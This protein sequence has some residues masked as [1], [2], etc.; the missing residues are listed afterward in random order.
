MAWFEGFKKVLGLGPKQR[1]VEMRKTIRVPCDLPVQLDIKGGPIRGKMLNVSTKGMRL[2][3]ETYLR[4][5]EAIEVQVHGKLR[6]KDIRLTAVVV[7]CKKRPG[8]TRIYD[9]GLHIVGH[10]KHSPGEV[11]RILAPDEAAA[12]VDNRQKRRSQRLP[13]SIPVAFKLQDGSSGAGVAKDLSRR[14]IL[15]VTRNPMATGTELDLSIELDR[16]TTVAARGSVKRCTSLADGTWETA[17]FMGSMTIQDRERMEKALSRL[18][19]A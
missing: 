3:V 2:E 17:C 8:A 11:L 7:W 19:P 10:S 5:K 14:G 15:F 12:K 6:A 18:R 16:D 1:L 4:P 9:S 13:C